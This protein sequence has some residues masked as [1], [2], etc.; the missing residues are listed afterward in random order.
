MINNYSTSLDHKVAEVIF[1]KIS[2]IKYFPS[3]MMKFCD[4]GYHDDKTNAIS[5]DQDNLVLLDRL[6]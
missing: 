5:V 6:K 3:A 4:F 1:I 2:Y